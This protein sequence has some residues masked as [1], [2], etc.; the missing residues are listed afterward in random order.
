MG[1]RL[2]DAVLCTR[3]M[4][5]LGPQNGSLGTVVEVE[6]TSRVL[7]DDASE[8]AG[9]ALAWSSGTTGNAEPSPLIC[10]KTSS[11]ATL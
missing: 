7:H 1:L 3:N 9:L 2:G 10:W 4:W 6:D 11:L 5:S 8:T